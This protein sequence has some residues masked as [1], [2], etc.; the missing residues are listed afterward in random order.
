M[1]T[2]LEALYAAR[3]AKAD[4]KWN[5]MTRVACKTLPMPALD[6]GYHGF[7]LQ[8]RKG[9]VLGYRWSIFPVAVEVVGEDYKGSC[10]R[11]DPTKLRPAGMVRID[12]S[13]TRD[14]KDFGAAQAWFDIHADLETAR[15]LVVDRAEAAKKRY[16]R[17]P[18]EA[19]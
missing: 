14:G 12:C 17:K 13:V 6:T 4:A 7:D 2:D 9:R 15:R 1:T 3:R 5:A 18:Q 19:R 8:D 16:A 10:Y 11:I